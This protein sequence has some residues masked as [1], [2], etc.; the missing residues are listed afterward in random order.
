MPNE[1]AVFRFNEDITIFGE[2]ARFIATSK[3]CVA[4][5]LAPQP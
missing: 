5:N 1:A 4:A 3:N 2:S